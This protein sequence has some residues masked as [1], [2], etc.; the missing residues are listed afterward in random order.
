MPTRTYQT[1]TQNLIQSHQFRHHPAH[2]QNLVQPPLSDVADD[3]APPGPAVTR[4]LVNRAEKE[5]CDACSAVPRR[6]GNLNW[7]SGWL[8]WCRTAVPGRA[9]DGAADRRAQ[10]RG[11]RP[12]RGRRTTDARCM[13][14]G[15]KRATEASADWRLPLKKT[16][17]LIYKHLRALCPLRNKWPCKFLISTALRV[18]WGTFV[19]SLLNYVSGMSSCWTLAFPHGSQCDLHSMLFVLVHMFLDVNLS[20]NTAR[21]SSYVKK[22]DTN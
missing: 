13:G 7:P 5:P 10:C 21:L 19:S 1:L 4:V 11:G 15:Q 18:V 6:D 8:T 9:A 3:M 22:M 20:L 17:I 14:G 12:T 2:W 16:A